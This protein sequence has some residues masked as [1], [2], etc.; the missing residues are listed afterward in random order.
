M[1]HKSETV[2]DINYRYVF[3]FCLA[4]DLFMDPPTTSEDLFALQKILSNDTF[5]Q[6][7]CNNDYT[8]QNSTDME[9]KDVECSA[10]HVGGAKAE[11]NIV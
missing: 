7:L 6:S 9:T 3:L 4:M 5:I 1:K 10:E 2:H 8:K 11:V